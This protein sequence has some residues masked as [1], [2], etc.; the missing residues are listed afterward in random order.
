MHA[1]QARQIPIA[2]LIVAIEQLEEGRPAR[3][4][5]HMREARSVNADEDVRVPRDGQLLGEGETVVLNECN[6][7]IMEQS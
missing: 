7:I 1:A 3:Q 2:R 5:Q 4:E 6:A